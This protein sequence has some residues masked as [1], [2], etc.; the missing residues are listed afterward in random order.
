MKSSNDKCFTFC[1]DFGYKIVHKEINKMII[2]YY[3]ETHR[4]DLFKINE[5]GDFIDRLIDQKIKINSSEQLLNIA[6]RY[7]KINAYE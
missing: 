2:E 1:D 4:F 7:Y 6:S 3:P 5:F